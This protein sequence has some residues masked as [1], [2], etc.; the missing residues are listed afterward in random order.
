MILCSEHSTDI[1]HVTDP[2]FV[3]ERNRRNKRPERKD[4]EEKTEKT[5]SPTVFRARLP[6][7][8]TEQTTSEH[9]LAGGE[10][11]PPPLGPRVECAWRPISPPEMR[12]ISELL[13]QNTHVREL[14]LGGAACG[15]WRRQHS[16]HDQYVAPA[17]HRRL[18]CAGHMQ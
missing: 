14:Q 10:G 12:L 7:S 5:M 4:G 8:R 16:N 1:G 15:D 3:K 6:L 9:L 17:S 2:L 18:M 11:T 13:A